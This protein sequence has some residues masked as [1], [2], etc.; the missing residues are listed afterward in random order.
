MP[1]SASSDSAAASKEASNAGEVAV[2][3]AEFAVKQA[4]SGDVQGGFV[5]SSVGEDAPSS[6]ASWQVM[7][8]ESANLHAH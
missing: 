7:K 1:I 6:C 3:T 2:A 8:P 5:V 4:G